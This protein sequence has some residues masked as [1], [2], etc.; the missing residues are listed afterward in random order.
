MLNQVKPI[1][2]QQALDCIAKSE[3]AASLEHHQLDFKREAGS[4][5]ETLKLLAEATV[6]FANADGG[7]I[8][9]GVAN[10]PPRSGSSLLGISPSL[11]VETARKGIFDRTVPPVTVLAETV[12]TAGVQLMVITVPQALVPCATTD[13]TATRRLDRECRPFTPDQQRDW[14]SARGM[15]DWSEHVTDVSVADADSREVARIRQMLQLVGKADLAALSNERLLEALRLT[16]N[17]SLRRAGVLLVGTPSD[18]ARSIP[19]YGFAYQYRPSPGQ[20]SLFRLRESEPVL[21][22]IEKLISTVQARSHVWPLNLA[23]GVQVALE[24]LPAAAVRELIVNAFVHRSYETNGTVDV[25]HSP[26]GLAVVSPGGLVSGVTPANILTH[27]S[28][29]RNRLLLE[30]IWMLGIAE[31]SGQGIDRVYR[32]LL[33]VGKAPVEFE[34]RGTTVRAYVAGARGDDAFVR[35]VTSLPDTHQGDVDVLLTLRQLCAKA[36]VRPAELAVVMQ[37]SETEAKQTLNRLSE[38]A[39]ALVEVTT[40]GSFRLTPAVL[41]ELG[42]AVRYRV[43]TGGDHDAKVGDHLA[44]YPTLSNRSLQ[45]MFDLSVFAARD[46]L[47]D[48]QRRGVVVKLSNAKSGPGVLYGPGPNLPLQ[49]KRRNRANPGDEG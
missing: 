46:L 31:R 41:A 17:G 21:T 39:T 30:T 6:C 9:V 13:G 4:L 12:E 28:T 44:E 20:E 47:R 37:R 32:E 1:G 11:T 7:S 3:S 38:G 33:R 36:T 14:L 29:P 48:L 27:P 5:R 49:S 35:F 23:G 2:W 25:D 40:R 22:G 19:T 16:E 45:R 15:M 34:D 43:S 24:E 18:I 8:V 10:T 42:R 26:D